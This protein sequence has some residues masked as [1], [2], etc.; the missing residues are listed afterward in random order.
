ME[1]LKVG[2]N[3]TVSEITDDGD[4]IMYDDD[5]CKHVILADE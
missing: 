4:V 5:G 3:L 2:D 1:A